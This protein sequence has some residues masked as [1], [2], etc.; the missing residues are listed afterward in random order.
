MLKKPIYLIVVMLLITGCGR[1]LEIIE[2]AVP[3]LTEEK[4]DPSRQGYESVKKY[5]TSDELPFSFG[6]IDKIQGHHGGEFRQVL[7]SEGSTIV[8][9]NGYRILSGGKI[10]LC[11][12]QTCEIRSY[13]RRN[14]ILAEG[15]LY[16]M[17]PKQTIVIE[18]Q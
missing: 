12:S 5:T 8:M 15:I 14:A 16:E 6:E 13:R 1:R 4:T 9:S 11:R 2:P 17:E 3:R 7:N 10:Y 18:R